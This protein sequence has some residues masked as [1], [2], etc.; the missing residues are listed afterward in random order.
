LALQPDGAG[1]AAQTL[2]NGGPRI[3]GVSFAV[4]EL[5][6]AQRWAERGYEQKL[7][8]YRGLWGESVLA[9]TQADLGLSIEL[10][11][12]QADRSPCPAPG[13]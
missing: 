3:L 11:A 2:A 12:I 10:H 5:G 9:P 6:R 13:P 7:A 4:A 8:T 1:L